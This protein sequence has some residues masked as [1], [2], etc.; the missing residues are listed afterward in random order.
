[1]DKAYHCTGLGIP[2]YILKC[3]NV[4]LQNSKVVQSTK[5][6]SYLR[7]FGAETREARAEERVA[8]KHPA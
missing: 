1:M 7:T 6:S 3:K 8:A 4:T 2:K 5:K